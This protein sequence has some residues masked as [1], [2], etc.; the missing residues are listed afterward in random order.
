[1]EVPY[2]IADDTTH[3]EF[4]KQKTQVVNDLKAFDLLS[5]ISGARRSHSG[6]WDRE[7]IRDYTELWSLH[8][9]IL[10]CLTRYA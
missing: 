1:M 10:K 3:L 9:V 7:I 8:A 5:S 2:T 6:Y 4:K